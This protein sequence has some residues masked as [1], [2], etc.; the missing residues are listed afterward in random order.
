MVVDRGE[1]V[2]AP[3]SSRAHFLSS[4]PWLRPL[5]LLAARTSVGESGIFVDLY[6]ITRQWAV[7]VMH[8]PS[9]FEVAWHLEVSGLSVA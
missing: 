1:Q 5:A 8:F 3:M 9:V 6:T 4:L 7:G 2:L